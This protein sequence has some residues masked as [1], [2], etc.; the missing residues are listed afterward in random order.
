MENKRYQEQHH[1]AYKSFPGKHLFAISIKIEKKNNAY[2]EAVFLEFIENFSEGNNKKVSML[3]TSS[4]LRAMSYGIRELLKHGKSSFKKFTD[5]TKAGNDGNKNEL[6]FAV[7]TKSTYYVNYASGNKK[8]GCGFDPYAFA[9]LSDT[10]LLLAEECD[11]ALYYYQ[12][13][14]FQ[15]S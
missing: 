2:S 5:P 9:A 13:I 12:R 11:K 15:N 14:H 6:T 3:V 1:V 7:D 8:I 10:I 4:D